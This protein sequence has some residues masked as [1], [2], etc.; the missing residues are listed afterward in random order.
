VH[1]YPVPADGI[2]EQLP[3]VLVEAVLYVEALRPEQQTG[4]VDALHLTGVAEHE[5]QRKL[6]VN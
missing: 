6:L 3:H 2:G 5:P 1:S 4:A